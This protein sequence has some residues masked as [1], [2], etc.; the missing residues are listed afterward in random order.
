MTIAIGKA[1]NIRGHV[2]IRTSNKTTEEDESVQG[3]Y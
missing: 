3:T 1:L 2:R